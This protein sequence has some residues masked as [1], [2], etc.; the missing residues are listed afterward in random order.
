MPTYNFKC[1][2]CEHEFEV[3][4]PMTHKKNPKCEKCKKK[5]EKLI[6]GGAGVIFKGTGFYETDYRRKESKPSKDKEQKSSGDSV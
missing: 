1:T 3:M 4:L 2:K 5:T 6:S